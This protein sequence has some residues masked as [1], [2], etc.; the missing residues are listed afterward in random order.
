M[1]FNNS[2]YFITGSNQETAG[3]LPL[4]EIANVKDTIQP[5]E[6]TSGIEIIDG[7]SFVF[8]HNTTRRFTEAKLFCKGRKISECI[9]IFTS[10]SKK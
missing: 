4:D 2:M 10:S 5:P 6:Q 9:F 8:D 3:A 7:R 1:E